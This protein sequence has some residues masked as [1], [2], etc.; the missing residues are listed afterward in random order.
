MQNKYFSLPV[1]YEVTPFDDKRFTKVKIY[2]MH[3]GENLNGSYFDFSSIDKAKNSICNIPILAFIKKDVYNNKDFGGHDVEVKLS[4]NGDVEFLYLERPIGVIPENNN[5]YHYEFINGKTYVVCDGYIWNEYANDAL[6]IINR[7]GAKSES[8][9]ISVDVAGFD[10]FDGLYHITDYSYLG[11]TL[12]GE[13]VTPAMV[14]CHAKIT[15]DNQQFNQSYFQVIKELN[16]T[17]KNFMIDEKDSISCLENDMESVSDIDTNNENE[18][19]INLDKEESSFMENEKEEFDTSLNQPMPDDANMP[20][21][22]CEDDEDEGVNVEIEVE[23]NINTPDTDESEEG[24]DTTNPSDSQNLIYTLNAEIVRLKDYCTALEQEIVP[25]RQFKA[26]TINQKT[27]VEKE[28]L[29]V[30]FSIGLTEDEMKPVKE[31][32]SELTLEQIKANL[33]EIFTLKNLE[34]LKAEKYSVNKEPNEVIMD[35]PKKEEINSRYA[36]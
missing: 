33:N 6:D 1:Q 35:L 32:M 24:E 12:L 13:D 4:S 21:G 31:K 29:F 26:D 28:Q 15:D 14:G 25:L 30:D 22:D 9:E 27:L 8:M 36:V 34:A 16:E 7:D 19:S 10:N 20:D 23:V 18:V 11:L 3:D 5:N 2:V 17:L